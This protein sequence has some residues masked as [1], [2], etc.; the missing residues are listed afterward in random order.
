M[1]EAMNE[2]KKLKIKAIITDFAAVLLMRYKQD[3]SFKREIDRRIERAE[4]IKSVDTLEDVDDSC[5][6]EL[7]TLTLGLS[8]GDLADEYYEVNRE[9][10]ERL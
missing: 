3:A 9:V 4:K 1:N 10:I 2:A 5:D 8:L 6:F 7:K